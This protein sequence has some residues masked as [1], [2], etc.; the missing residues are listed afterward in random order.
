MLIGVARN[1][2]LAVGVRQRESSGSPGAG[3]GGGCS[4]LDYP[5]SFFSVV[6]LC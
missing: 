3:T 6:Y 4:V 5:Q 2:R 1:L